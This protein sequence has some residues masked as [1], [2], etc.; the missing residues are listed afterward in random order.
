M[1]PIPR[2]VRIVATLL[3]I[4][5]ITASVADQAK[6]GNAIASEPLTPAAQR[7]GFKVPE[8]F[9]VELVAS[10]QTGVP[11]PVSIAFD[12][13]GRLWTQT[14]TEYPNDNNPEIWSKPGADR[15]VVIDRP[16]LPGPQEPRIFAEGM[17]MPMGVLPYGD[18]AIVAQGPAI[19]M[20]SDTDNDGVADKRVELVTGFGVQDTHTL[21]HQLVR[22]PGGRI[23]FSQGLLNTGT[24][25]DAGGREH[26]FDRTLVATITPDG[27]DLRVI[28]AG[29]NNIWAWERDRL[30]RVFIHEANDF[31]MSLAPFEPDSSYPAFI[32]NRIHPAAPLHPPTAEGLNLG[33]TGFCGIAI[34]MDRSGSFPEPWHGMFFV[35]DPIFGKI[36]AVGG[37]PG[38]QGVWSFTKH[39]EFLV[40]DDPMFRP[41]AVTFGPDGCLYVVDWYDRII[42]HNEVALDH[43]GRDK[44]HGRIWRVRHRGQPAPTVED[45]GKLPASAL[46][47]LLESDNTWAMRA[48][49]HQMTA[50]KDRSVVPALVALVKNPGKSTD[51]RIHALW[52]LE[53]L[54]PFD[55]DLWRQLLA[56]SSADLRREAV[57]ALSTLRVTAMTAAP[58]LRGLAG[59]KD[60]P[61]RYEVLRF[62]RDAEGVPDAPT[63]AWLRAWSEGTAPAN[64]TGDFLALDG[65]Y[66][67]AFQDFLLM[68]VET[69]TRLPVF[70]TSRW[71]GVVARH[72]AP[73][74]PAAKA[75]RIREVMAAM[76]GGDA[77]AGRVLVES[78]CLTCH[79]IGGE[80][81]GFAPP[82]DG[83]AS[84]DPEGLLTAI[85]DPDAAIENV[86]RNYRVVMN[87]GVVVEG[88][89][90]GEKDGAIT[91]RLMGGGSHVVPYGEI[92]TAGYVEGQSMMPD[93]TGG[94][95]AGQ[96]ASIAAY[97]LSLK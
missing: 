94:L 13:A 91:L 78:L 5:G 44:S 62:F 45:H 73:A 25:T 53:E 20:L 30:G 42:S 64:K 57:R 17:V 74:D 58:L 10:E 56:D 4:S 26:R 69:R 32:E 89:K 21:P 16:H 31:G 2:P 8:G 80:G 47:G 97:L 15:V 18:G 70:V 12:D 79:A 19:L 95:T 60:W 38:D 63:L 68:L 29:M 11:N 39:S 14:A 40:C 28:S 72:P 9:V 81:A 41:I 22:M 71:D 7:A 55:P 6:E 34:C 49:W 37:K 75:A 59:E 67:R 87:D 92:A 52:V 3:L 61:V 33:G 48:A 50:R 84:R 51:A 96:V 90:A 82:L 1:F 66:Q 83:S 85:I 77:R 76:P 36:H 23:G 24:I 93:L 54:A 65:S 86:F 88:F 27:R 43:P 35:A 46:P